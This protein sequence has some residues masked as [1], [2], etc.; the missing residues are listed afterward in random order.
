MGTILSVNVQ[1]KGE[2]SMKQKKLF[3][4]LVFSLF[5]L[6]L[7]GQLP[8][9]T[10]NTLNNSAGLPLFSSNGKWQ[11]GELEKRLQ[12]KQ[13]IFQGGNLRR[14]VFLQNQTVFN[15]P[16]T[17]ML[18]ISNPDDFVTQIDVI[19]SNKGDSAAAGNMKRDIRQA[20][21][22]LKNFFT[23][24][25][26]TPKKEKFGPKGMQNSVLRWNFGEVSLILESSRREY[27]ILHICYPAEKHSLPAKNNAAVHKDDFVKN[28]KINDFGD[29]YIENIP[30]V[31]QGGK[32]YCSPATV[33][34]V[35]RYLGVSAI[36]MHHLAAAADTG[37][38]GGTSYSAMH[39][40]INRFCRNFG[41]NTFNC[42]EIKLDTCRKYIAAGFPV[43][44]SMNVN[45]SLLQAMKFSRSSRSGAESPK[46][47]LKSIRKQKVNRGGDG[48]MC[49]VVGFNE[50]TK[51]IAISNSWGDRESVPAWIT[52]KAALRVSHGHTMVLVPKK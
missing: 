15:V 38:G 45:P 34:R 25:F 47:W 19:Y 21:R 44:W 31:N 10:C 17:E 50:K 27:T 23:S 12:Q 20:N 40:A 4:F 22:S 29:V 37:R 16:A 32:G 43:M 2:F 14:S 42:G 6:L 7:C 36:N 26:G 13:L 9:V 28:V 41:L 24:Q 3:L 39:S 49:L 11:R 52:L 18:L 51:E 48:H 35:L 1:Q 33:E 8:D 46:S 30:M 5:S